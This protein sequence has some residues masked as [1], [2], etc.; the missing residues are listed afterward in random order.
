MPVPKKPRRKAEAAP[1]KAAAAQTIPDRR[2]MESFLAT[3]TGGSADDALSEA[4][5]GMYDAALEVAEALEMQVPEA[6]GL[7]RRY[8]A[9]RTT[10]G[11]RPFG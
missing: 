8:P 7:R 5:S 11:W 2:A 9:D 6:S 1:P 4:Q 3:V 10:T